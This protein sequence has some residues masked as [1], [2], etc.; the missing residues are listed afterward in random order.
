MNNALFW[1]RRDLRATDNAGLYHAL[2]NARRVYCVFV[3][4]RAI[5]DALPSKTDRRVEFIWELSQRN[6][7]NVI[8]TRLSQQHISIYLYG[9]IILLTADLRSFAA[10][11]LLWRSFNTSALASA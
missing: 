1:F 7:D 6:Q 11:C 4:D 8:C 3:F 5:L 9:L 10:L 2:K